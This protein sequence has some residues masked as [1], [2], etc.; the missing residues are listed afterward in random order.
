MVPTGDKQ[1]N[2]C[3]Q[4]PQND[5]TNAFVAFR[6]F[7]DDQISSLMNLAFGSNPFSSNPSLPAQQLKKEYEAWLRETRESRQRLEREAEEA[8][9]VMDLYIR[10]HRDSRDEKGPLVPGHDSQHESRCPFRNQGTHQLS[11]QETN[12][13]CSYFDL[14]ALKPHIPQALGLDVPAQLPSLQASDSSPFIPFSYMLHSEYSPLHLEQDKQFNDR[15]TIWRAAFEDLISLANGHDLSQGPWR[16]SDRAETPCEWLQNMICMA[17]RNREMDLALNKK[18][19]DAVQNRVL[20][21]ENQKKLLHARLVDESSNSRWG[22]QKA[23][24][25]QEKNDDDDED[26][27][28]EEDDNDEIGNEDNDE[29][30]EDEATELDLYS[31]VIE[32]VNPTSGEAT[33]S[34]ILAHLQRDSTASAL[35]ESYMPSVLSTLTTTEK[36]TLKDGTTHTKVVLKRR[37]SD[38]RE[39]STETVHTQNA[40]PEQL[41]F[42]KS[43]D[44]KKKDSKEINTKERKGWFW[45]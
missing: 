13:L 22:A 35:D 21:S 15:G 7:A 8:A 25:N 26:D 5:Q 36:T 39:E 33:K 20:E 6:R 40:M 3:D 14:E 30:D 27:D 17:V 43:N 19:A 23:T 18:G 24:G 31:R 32:H 37:F 44:T 34:R 4:D 41:K 9:N 29:E 2:S 16:A 1:S 28:D 11:D 10:A 38:G 45:S 42:S 12:D